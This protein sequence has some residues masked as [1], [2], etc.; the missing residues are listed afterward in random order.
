MPTLSSTRVVANIQTGLSKASGPVTDTIGISDQTGN[1]YQSGTGAGKA[2]QV[3]SGRLTLSTTTT[4]LDLKSLT[5]P[6]GN[7]LAFGIVS[8]IKI[9]NQS[10]ASGE[11][12]IVGTG[13]SSTFTMPIGA[14]LDPGSTT[15]N[16]LGGTILW[17]N[18]AGVV[19]GTDTNTL[20]VKS[21]AGS[22]VPVDVTIIGRSA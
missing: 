10:K 15:T 12:V 11:T 16:T 17:E 9:T 2:D 22:A 20:N 21:G 8:A 5:D 19:V 7:A 6:A 3:Y 13:M 4:T 18:P 1:S 14:T